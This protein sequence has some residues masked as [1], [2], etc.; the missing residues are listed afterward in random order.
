MEKKEQKRL[1]VDF[2][3]LNGKPGTTLIRRLD[4]TALV[5][6]PKGKKIKS[7]KEVTL[8]GF[9]QRSQNWAE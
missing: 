8:H 4:G 9:K 3:L 5:P 1:M 6:G 2:R 7:E